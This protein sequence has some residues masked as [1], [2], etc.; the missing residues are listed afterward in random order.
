[1]KKPVKPAVKSGV[2]KPV[3]KKPAVKKPVV[4]KPVKP[5]VKKPAVKTSQKAS[6]A[7]RNLKFKIAAGIFLAGGLGVLGWAARNHLKVTLTKE[8]FTTEQ[9][10]IIRETFNHEAND[11]IST[12]IV[13]NRPSPTKE[14]LATLASTS[15]RMLNATGTAAVHMG[16][17]IVKI[18][19]GFVNMGNAVIKTVPIVGVLATAVYIHIWYPGVLDSAAA[20]GQAF[21]RNE[22]L[23]LDADSEHLQGMIKGSKSDNI[24]VYGASNVVLGGYY[25]LRRIPVMW[26]ASIASTAVATARRAAG[27]VGAV[28]EVPGLM[29][30]GAVGE[31]P[32]L[33]RF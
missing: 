30:A 27:A 14:D 16:N 3:V 19:N 31:V 33:I 9:N 28:G 23:H 20:Y 1:M 4:K 29:A 13:T 12:G 17:G 11:A 5:A 26:L 18:G 7:K 22:Q 21:F 24:L 15:I 32:R 25:I 8:N 6:V 10:A 2:K